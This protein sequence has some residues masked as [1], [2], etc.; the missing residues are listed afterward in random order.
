[1]AAR[2]ML[3]VIFRVVHDLLEGGAWPLGRM[4]SDCRNAI[5][6]RR[7]MDTRTH[8]RAHATLATSGL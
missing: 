8:A 3:D 5:R 4:E 2:L 1:M 7:S 6:K